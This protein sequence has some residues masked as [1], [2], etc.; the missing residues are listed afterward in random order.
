MGSEEE[1]SVVVLTDE[2]DNIATVLARSLEFEVRTQTLK[3]VI[4]H[5]G[6]VHNF[7][8]ISGRS[9]GKVGGT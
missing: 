3:F 8:Q 6:F 9:I 7:V 2:G 1:Y 4:R 5:R